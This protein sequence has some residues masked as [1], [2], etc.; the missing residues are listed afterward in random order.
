MFPLRGNDE[1]A[2]FDKP[3]KTIIDLGPSPYYAP[4][5]HVQKTLTCYTYPT[6]MVKEY[7]E[8][9]KGAEWLSI[10]RFQT[11]KRPSCSMRH[12]RGEKVIRWKEW[13]GYFKGAKDS[14]VFF[15]A[16]DGTDGGLPFVIYDARTGRQIFEDS[17]HLRDERTPTASDRF[18]I[19]RDDRHQIVL[20]YL[21]VVSATCNVA[22][23]GSKCWNRIRVKHGIPEGKEPVCSGYEHPDPHWVSAVAYPVS[24]VL[25]KH[26]EIKAS[27]GPTYCWPVD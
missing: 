25:S 21:R 17:A 4:T 3:L 9:Q 20:K 23:D 15:D 26:P 19:A 16:P 2:S 12:L 13:S 14:F 8:G 11:R 24:V 10:S 1:N 22:T 6:F 5:A 18:Q 7:D 27:A